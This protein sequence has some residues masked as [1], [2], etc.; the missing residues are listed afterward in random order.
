MRTPKLVETFVASLNE[1]LAKDQLP[2]HEEVP[3]LKL[4]NYILGTLAPGYSILTM[5]DVEGSLAG[6][7]PKFT[8]TTASEQ[9][10]LRPETAPDEE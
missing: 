8:P 3:T 4:M 9:H 10:T 5:R 1:L 7:A 2:L 6:F